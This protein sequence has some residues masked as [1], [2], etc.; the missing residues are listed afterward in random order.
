MGLGYA[1]GFLVRRDFVRLIFALFGFGLLFR[2]ALGR[3]VIR[4]VPAR[5]FELKTSPRDGLCQ[6]A[7]AL[8]ASLKRWIA[9]FLYYLDMG[10]ALFTSIFVD[11]H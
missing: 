5:P 2:R 1:L 8:R 7:A 6:L 9:Y 10:A 4:C 3:R 11:R